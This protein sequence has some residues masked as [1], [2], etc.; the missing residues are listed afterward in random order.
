MSRTL[1]PCV[2]LPITGRVIRLPFPDIARPVDGGWQLEISLRAL[3]THP[4]DTHIYVMQGGN[5][6]SSTKATKGL[7]HISGLS[8]LIVE[9]DGPCC[10]GIDVPETLHVTIGVC[11]FDCCLNCD[12]TG[13][14]FPITYDADNDMWIGTVDVCDQAW[15]VK[16]WCTGSAWMA[17]PFC[18]SGGGN[19]PYVM[20]VDCGPP[21]STSTAMVFSSPDCCLTTSHFGTPTYLVHI[22]A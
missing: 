7:C 14:T 17:Q 20:N 18:S 4:G 10:P 15:G 21:F 8:V 22:D 1:T 6:I 12:P 13:K 2:E 9:D 16:L 3:G 5:T 19:D 11:T